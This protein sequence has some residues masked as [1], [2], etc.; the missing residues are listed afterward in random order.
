MV[1]VPGKFYVVTC[2]AMLQ[3][4]ISGARAFF[5]LTSSN[6]L[7]DHIG[8]DWSEQTSLSFVCLVEDIQI[9]LSFVCLVEDIQRSCQMMAIA[10]IAA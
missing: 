1:A 10:E 7:Q 9:S 8:A 3:D 4:F 2:Y 5:A 6:K